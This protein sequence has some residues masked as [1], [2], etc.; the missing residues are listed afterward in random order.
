MDSRTSNATFRWWVP[1]SYSSKANPETVQCEWIPEHLDQVNI[2]LEANESQWVI[3]NVDQVGQQKNI[4]Q[5]I[6]AWTISFFLL[7]YYR[8][9]YDERNWNLLTQQLL[10]DPREISVINRAQM[11]DD[12]FNLARA[13]LLD[14]S[15]AFNVTRYLQQ[16]LEYIPWRSAATGFKFLDAMLCRTPIYGAFQVGQKKARNRV[17]KS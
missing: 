4:F 17:Q 11:I 15:I 3:F 6:S 16:E 2:S 10:D 13:G 12:S 1:L 9:N 7:G 5:R 14:Y 8:V